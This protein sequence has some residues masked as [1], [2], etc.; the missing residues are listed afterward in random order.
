MFILQVDIYKG[1]LKMI[2]RT[3]LLRM[4]MENNPGQNPAFVLEQYTLYL[5]GLTSIHGENFAPTGACCEASAECNTEEVVDAKQTK[6]SLTCGYTKRD[7]KVKP[8][9]AI[10]EDK[11]TCCIC[12]KEG[13]TITGRHLAHHNGITPEGYKKLCGYSA[14]QPLM[15]AAHLASMKKNVMKAQEAR[16]SKKRKAD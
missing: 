1:D 3:E 11:I 7:L 13:Q 6:A 16:K 4:I 10:K 8:K 15:S 14:D 9:D 5:K 2:D 12:G